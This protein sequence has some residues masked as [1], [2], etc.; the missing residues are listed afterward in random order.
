MRINAMLYRAPITAPRLGA[1]C[2]LRVV[3]TYYD[4]I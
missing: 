1:N 3:E 2:T 4:A